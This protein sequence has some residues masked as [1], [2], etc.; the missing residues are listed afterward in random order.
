MPGPACRVCRRLRQAARFPVAPT[1][2]FAPACGR[3]RAGPPPPVRRSPGWSAAPARKGSVPSAKRFAQAVG[4]PRAAGSSAIRPAFRR[5]SARPAA[6]AAGGSPF[7]LLLARGR[8]SSR[9]A[10][11]A[12]ECGGGKFQE[13]SAADAVG[14]RPGHLPG[15]QIEQFGE[16]APR[17]QATLGLAQRRRESTRKMWPTGSLSLRGDG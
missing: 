15:E 17:L 6:C 13:I 1:G 3:D 8:A 16:L 7:A 9:R 14:R 12:T 4:S 5:Q 2:P 11:Q 10:W